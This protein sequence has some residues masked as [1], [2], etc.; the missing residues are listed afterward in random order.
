MKHITL[1]CSQ[2]AKEQCPEA[3]RSPLLVL[4]II[5]IIRSPFCH[6]FDNNNVSIIFLAISILLPILLIPPVIVLLIIIIIRFLH[7][8]VINMVAGV[9]IRWIQ[10]NFSLHL[11][12]EGLNLTVLIGVMEFEIVN[13]HVLSSLPFLN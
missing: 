4:F 10:L 2:I 12:Q 9:K 7:N 13:G 6:F 3:H 11:L 5:I 1:R 8:V